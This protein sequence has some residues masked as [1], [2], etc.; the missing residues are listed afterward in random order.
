MAGV[1]LVI[2]CAGDLLIRQ[3]LRPDFRTPGLHIWPTGQLTVQ[4]SKHRA[5]HS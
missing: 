5:D 1:W 4:V 2:Y 3:L